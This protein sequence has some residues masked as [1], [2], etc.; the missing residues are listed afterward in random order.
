MLDEAG[1]PLVAPALRGAISTPAEGRVHRHHSTTCGQIEYELSYEGLRGTV[2][3]GHIHFGQ[4]HT[5]W[6]HRR[7]AVPDHGRIR[8]PR[9]LPRQRRYVRRKVL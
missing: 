9:L 7:L 4:R 8:P 5:R 1:P 3:Q 6:R 2:T